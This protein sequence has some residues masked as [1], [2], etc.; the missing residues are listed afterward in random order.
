MVTDKSQ[1]A[2][3]FVF[4]NVACCPCFI[5]ENTWQYES[6]INAHIMRPYLYT[7]NTGFVQLL[8]KTGI[9]YT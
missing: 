5:K 6:S 7:P 3:C 1:F 4:I 8:E 9:F 2:V